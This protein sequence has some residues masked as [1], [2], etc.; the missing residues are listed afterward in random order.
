MF[1][2]V[3]ANTETSMGYADTFDEAV[4]KATMLRIKL[5]VRFNGI[6]IVRL[7]TPRRIRKRYVHPSYL[8]QQEAVRE[9][10]KMNV[11]RNKPRRITDE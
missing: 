11:P 7:G 8:R 3:L 9:R 4:A 6:Q 2:I 10:M 5:G 1:N